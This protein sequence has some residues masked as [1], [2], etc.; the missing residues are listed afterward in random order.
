MVITNCRKK[1]AIFFT[2][3]PASESVGRLMDPI[4]SVAYFVIVSFMF[5]KIFWMPSG[6][7]TSTPDNSSESVSKNEVTAWIIFGISSIRETASCTISE[8][9]R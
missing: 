8:I 6:S 2:Y 3:P 9:A 1:L 7:F 5:P 4:N